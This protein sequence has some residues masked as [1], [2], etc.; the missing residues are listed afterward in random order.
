[1]VDPTCFNS[2]TAMRKQISGRAD[3]SATK[4]RTSPAQPGV[5]P[6]AWFFLFSFFSLIHVRFRPLFDG[7]Y[8]CSDRERTSV[9]ASNVIHRVSSPSCHDLIEKLAV[10]IYLCARVAIEVSK[11][12]RRGVLLK[13]KKDQAARRLSGL[14]LP[15]YCLSCGVMG[16]S[17]SL[18]ILS[19]R[20]ISHD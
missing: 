12:V 1:M 13:T 9:A 2:S 15:S 14:M 18:P 16:H 17:L 5:S 6:L 3:D 20:P 8:T 7:Y 11:P 4:Q 10:H 19:D